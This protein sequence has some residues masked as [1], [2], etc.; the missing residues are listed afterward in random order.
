MS[1][2]LMPPFSALISLSPKI[3]RSSVKT[4]EFAESMIQDLRHIPNITP[5]GNILFLGETEMKQLFL[6]AAGL[7][8]FRLPLNLQCDLLGK[9]SVAT[10]MVVVTWAKL[11]C[12]YMLVKSVWARESDTSRYFTPTLTSGISQTKGILSTICNPLPLPPPTPTQSCLERK[13]LA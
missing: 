7:V 5:H 3:D 6:A 12:V 13:S 9:L 11:W 8:L 1:H 2:I 4:V 10:C